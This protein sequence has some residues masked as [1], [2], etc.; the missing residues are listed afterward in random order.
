MHLKSIMTPLMVPTADDAK[1]QDPNMTK[2]DDHEQN[3]NNSADTTDD[4]V[5]AEKD[6]DDDK[7]THQITTWCIAG[8]MVNCMYN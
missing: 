5:D 2:A 8:I 6:V 4:T 1:D 3:T 7:Y